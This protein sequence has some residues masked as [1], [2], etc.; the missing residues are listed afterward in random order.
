M[1]LIVDDVLGSTCEPLIDFRRRTNMPALL[2]TDLSKIEAFRLTLENIPFCVKRMV[3]SVI[4]AY[5]PLFQNKGVSLTLKLEEPVSDTLFGDPN[6]LRQVFSNLLSNALKF[7]PPG[8]RSRPTLAVRVDGSLC[9]VERIVGHVQFTLRMFCGDSCLINGTDKKVCPKGSFYAN[10]QR[11]KE[12]CNSCSLEFE[13]VDDGIGLAPETIPE[14][15]KAYSQDSTSRARVS[16]GT[17]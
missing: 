15:F 5:Q 9:G 17:G 10:I 7:V 4:A 16:G 1:R 2:L 11:R 12:P 3:Q 6:R 8:G 13:V 14:L